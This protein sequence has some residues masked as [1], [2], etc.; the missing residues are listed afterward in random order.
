MRRTIPFCLAALIGLGAAGYGV[1]WLLGTC[2]P[3]DRL[4]GVSGCTEVVR[5]AD[6]APVQAV[7]LTAPD[8][9]GVSSLFGHAYTPDGWRPAM[10]RLDLETGKELSRYPVRAL[11]G[12]GWILPAQDGKRGLFTCWVQRICTE[13]GR[14]AAIISLVDASVIETLDLD[15]SNPVHFPGDAAPPG[16]DEW[17][18]VFAANGERIIEADPDRGLILFDNEGAEIAKLIDKARWDL[19]VSDLSIS[20]SGTRIAYFEHARNDDPARL[21]V[22]DAL[23]G[24][25]VI[26]RQFDSSYRWRSNP[27]W[28]A[29]STR[30]ALIRRD[31]PDTLL[32][33]HSVS[34]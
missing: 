26:D 34:R 15:T 31:G 30:L 13:D 8:A 16:G 14:R 33:L 5:I 24:E 10:V 17:R 27:A 4:L 1:Y 18:R 3:L 11:N 9:E 25:A 23:T 21:L 20:P 22:W 6:F 19:T 29:Q 2:R 28:T 32:E 12:F 7:A